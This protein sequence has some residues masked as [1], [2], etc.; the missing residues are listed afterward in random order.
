MFLFQ[1]IDRSILDLVD[2]LRVCFPRNMYFDAGYVMFGF[3]I[4]NLAKIASAL[5]YSLDSL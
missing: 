2:H 5:P 4:D 1:V 3:N